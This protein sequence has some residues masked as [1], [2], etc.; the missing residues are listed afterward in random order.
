MMW[1]GVVIFWIVMLV[2]VALTYFMRPEGATAE[3]WYKKCLFL[4][5][6]ELA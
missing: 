1:L 4:G 3:D 2:V 5:A 6:N